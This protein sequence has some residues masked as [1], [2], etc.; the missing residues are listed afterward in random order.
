[1]PVN[2]ANM[3][4][5]HVETFM[6]T[7]DLWAAARW[8]ADPLADAAVQSIA[9]PWPA[10]HDDDN[11]ATQIAPIVQRLHLATRAMAQWTDNASLAA[12]RPDPSLPPDIAA[13]LQDYVRQAAALPA[14]ADA[15]LIERAEQVFV[16]H[17]VLSC[18][19]L[20]CASLPE[21]YVLP[22]LSAVLHTT[23][24]LEDRT[25]HRIR[26]TAAMIFPVMM[27]GGLTSERGGGIAQVLKVRL[28]HATVRHLVLHGAPGDTTALVAPLQALASSRNMHHALAAHGWDAPAQG[29]PCNQLELAYTLLTFHYVFLRGLR[30]L[31]IPLP[32]HDERAYLHAWNVMGHV[33]GIE[34]ALMPETMDQARAAFATLQAQGRQYEMTARLPTRGDCRP[35]LGQALMGCMARAIPLDVFKPVPVLMTRHLCGTA[36]AQDIGIAQQPVP[37][38]SRWV[39]GAAL[40]IARLIDGVARLFSP[41]FSIARFLTRLAGYPLVCKLLMDQTR[42]LALPE[43]LRAQMRSTVDGWS[44]DVHA[45]G[46]LNRVEDRLTTRGRWGPARPPRVP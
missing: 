25:E 43:H 34:T 28:I 11:A 32:A 8:R 21:C 29:L 41:R 13:A 4:A 5:S 40:L 6:Q 9:G 39:F 18:T 14:W 46:W 31:H 10:L 26:A 22:D 27:P 1:M 45:P 7:P 19:L 16:D 23:G 36:T 15:A 30:D 3:V 33:L 2:M 17:G 24:Q 38:L 44:D 37:W 12:W 20:F 35:A 42:P